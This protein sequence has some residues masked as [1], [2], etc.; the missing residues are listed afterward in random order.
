MAV[1]H[2]VFQG[3]ATRDLELKT[4]QSGIENVKFT[5]AWSEKYKETER[6]CFLTCKAWRQT[7]TFLDKYFRSKG[8]EM[9][10]EGALE[11]EEWEDKD[12]NKRI[13]IVLNVDKVHFCG[14]KQDAGTVHPVE[15]AP[16]AAAPAG[17][18]FVE[19]QESELPF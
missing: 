13:Q 10:V 12:G 5:L 7:A 17:G 6:K 3:R 8:S 18:G 19:V 14:K 2:L 1:N 4:T 16:A 15:D 9:V 11:T